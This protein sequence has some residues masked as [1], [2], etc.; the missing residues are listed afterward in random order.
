MQP[1][2]VHEAICNLDEELIKEIIGENEFL[3]EI[4]VNNEEI[5]D[6]ISSTEKF[7]ELMSKYRFRIDE[8]DIRKAMDELGMNKP[9]TEQEIK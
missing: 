4:Y 5:R 6:I 3:T 7:R 8:D 1:E 2:E 9:L